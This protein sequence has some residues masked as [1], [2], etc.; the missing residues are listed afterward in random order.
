[1]YYFHKHNFTVSGV[2]L[3]KKSESVLSVYQSSLFL[4][5]LNAYV[6]ISYKDIVITKSYGYAPVRGTPVM[7]T[8]DDTRILMQIRTECA[9][10]YK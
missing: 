6:T 2:L 7:M 5:I 3:K 1:M 9:S 10:L 4:I 8:S